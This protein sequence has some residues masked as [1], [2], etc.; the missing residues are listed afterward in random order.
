MAEKIKI[1]GK[2]YKVDSLSDESK[3]QLQNISFAEAELKR[4][5]AMQALA[6][7][8]LNAYKKALVDSLEK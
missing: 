8:A 7:T 6:Q 1:N 2:E 5:H 3:M 4:L